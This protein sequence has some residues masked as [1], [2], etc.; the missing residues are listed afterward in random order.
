MALREDLERTGNWLFRW[1]S[2]LPLMMVAIVLTGLMRFS[3]DSERADDL[4]EMFCLLVSFAGLAIRFYTV[5]HAPRGTS[6]GNTR[7]QVAAALNT[8]GSYSIVRH[9]LY[10]GNF[11]IWLGISLFVQLW[12]ISLIFILVFW[13]YYERIIFAEEE[14]LRGKFDRDFLEWSAATPAFVPKF[15]NWKDPDGPFSWKA[16]LRREYSGFFA[17]IATFTFLELVGD[18]IAKGRWELDWMW[19]VIFSAGLV[20]YVVLRTLKKKTRLLDEKRPETREAA[21]SLAKEG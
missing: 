10:V 9:P 11:L 12:W 8:T 3:F 5:G 6:G 21:V 20:T 19:A 13:L 4:W 1:R 16:A 14:F 7:G 17:I 18:R 15:G 2:Y